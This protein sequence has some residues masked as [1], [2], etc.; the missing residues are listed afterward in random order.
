LA[1]PDELLVTPL[2]RPVA[3]HADR[4][5]QLVG[6]EHISSV[7]TAAIGSPTNRAV[8]G[9]ER[10]QHGLVHERGHG[11]ERLQPVRF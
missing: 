1:P 6:A 11:L 4:G 3:R 10:L 7:T 5:Q 8:A 9:Q 2:D